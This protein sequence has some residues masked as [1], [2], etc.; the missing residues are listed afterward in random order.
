M[1][2]PKPATSVLPSKRH[3]ES[4]TGNSEYQS[5][6]VTRQ[7]KIKR[8]RERERETKQTEIEKNKYLIKILK[9]ILS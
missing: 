1:P 6:I 2:A 7:D 5:N 3:D 4:Q 8:K 9:T